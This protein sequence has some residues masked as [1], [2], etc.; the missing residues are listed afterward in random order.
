MDKGLNTETAIFSYRS[1]PVKGPRSKRVESKKTENARVDK[2]I[3]L[4][5]TFKKLEL[6]KDF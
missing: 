4:R 3:F 5:D 6:K 2:K 1:K